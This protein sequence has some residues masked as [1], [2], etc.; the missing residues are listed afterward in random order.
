M[1][2]LEELP[3][4]L[5]SGRI[6]SEEQYIKI[7]ISRIKTKTIYEGDCWRYTGK[8]VGKGYGSIT[9]KNRTIRLN[10]FI[11]YV[12]H[13]MNLGSIVMQANHTSNCKYKDC[14]NP[15]HIYAGTQQENVNDQIKAGTFYYGTNNLGLKKQKELKEARIRDAITRKENE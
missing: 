6:I 1:P 8:K 7:L 9:Y 2:T 13:G 10:R 11:A 15:K 5:H 3:A 4:R 12:Y 14:W